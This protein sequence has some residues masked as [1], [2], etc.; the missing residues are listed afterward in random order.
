MGIISMQPPA[1]DTRDFNALIRQ[2]KEM[3]PYYTPEWRFTPDEP[4]PGAALFLIFARMFQENIKCF[5]KVPL[6]NLIAFINMFDVSTMSRKPARAYVTFKLSTGAREPV[7]IPA[8]TQVSA[9]APDGGAPVV[10]ETERIML[11]TPA[12]LVDAYNVS[13]WQ[14]KILRIP[15]QCLED[16]RR[17]DKPGFRLFDFSGTGNLQ[18]HS[19]LIGDVDLFNVKDTA[20]VRL[21]IGNS[22]RQFR[23]SEA[24]EKLADPDCVEWSYGGDDGWHSFDEVSAEGNRL[25]LKK[26]RPVPIKYVEVGGISSRWI[27]GRVKNYAG[28]AWDE[29]EMDHIGVGVDYYDIEN[30]GGISPDMVYCND[31]QLDAAGFFPFREFFAQYDSFYISCQEAFSKKGSTVTIRFD[32]KHIENKMR[33]NPLDISW[34]LIMRPKDFQEPKPPEVFVQ[35]VC[36]EYWD[37]S[38]WVKLFSSREYEEIFFRPGQVEKSISFRCPR[39]MRETCVN[40]HLNYWIRARIVSIHNMY[41]PDALYFSPWIENIRMTYEYGDG[42]R[43]ADYY[44]TCNNMDYRDRT[45]DVKSGKAPFAPFYTLDCRWP[46]FYMGF[47]APP[48]KGPIS[49]YFSIK[50]Q[51]QT[52]GEMPI[53]TWEYLRR[54][55]GAPEWAELK[56]SDGTRAF[57]RSGAVVFAGPPDFG[58]E[59]LF[60]RELYW[61]RVVNCDGRFEQLPEGLATPG[62]NGIYLNCTGVVQQ[63][64]VENERPER[65]DGVSGREYAL[66]KGP[67]I[68][69]EV[70]VNEE[71]C[72]TDGERGLLLSDQAANVSEI[73]DASGNV[74]QFWVRWVPVEDFLESGPQDRHY[75]IE[76]HTGRIYFGDGENGKAPPSPGPG[77]IKVN[78][79]TGGGSRG[80]VGPFGISRLQNSIAFLEEVFN[81]EPSGGGCD[82]ETLEDA[83]RRG[84]Y[85]LR[86][87][88]RAVTAEDF[89]WL[90]RQASQNIAKVK[91][92]SNFNAGEKKETGCLTVVIVPKGWKEGLAVQ[93]EVKEQVEKYLMERAANSVLWPG[94]IRVIEPAYVEISVYAALTVNN[95]DALVSVEK[96][97]V[98]R[99][100]QFLDPLTGHYGGKGWEI[101]QL[102][103]ISVFY[104]LLKAIRN[105]NYVE[106]VTMT[107]YK[108]QDGVKTEADSNNLPDLPH[109]MVVNGRHRVDVTVSQD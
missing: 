54:G 9:A 73:R 50:K 74:S 31:M 71:G 25:L 75:I 61:I 41:A 5:N 2:M 59:A 102:P 22:L 55:P 87:R 83:V 33:T 48:V 84:P 49:I 58:R 24:C 13:T 11:A 12:L 23:E 39:D 95:M 57:S 29:V 44:L 93:P 96:E 4:D 46:S 103:Q 98:N 60:G 91:C 72:L 40:D 107:V 36:W 27:R 81:P 99:L 109:G 68:S 43:P 42:S 105:V 28:Y 106:K 17:A 78:Y 35:A 90:A 97:A 38:G 100:N 20:L 10:F 45:A 64:S 21:E 6:K 108:I 56:V 85:L 51:K 14:D 79:K 18:D 26:T 66:T 30:R 82:M 16:P 101:G 47:D 53:F 80:N 104:A 7:I 52:D 8:G 67:V 86:H 32:L 34:K 37:G 62:I 70:W 65:T 77:N 3:A 1:I 94:N 92:L 19:L 63:E 88:N 76:R 89:E 15:A 69:E